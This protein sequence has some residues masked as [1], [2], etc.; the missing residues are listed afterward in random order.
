MK[1]LSFILSFLLCMHAFLLAQIT[2][3]PGKAWDWTDEVTL[4]YD[5]TQ[6]NQGLI[7]HQR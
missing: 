6:G 7:D 5:A 2:I 4:T 1:K 3:T